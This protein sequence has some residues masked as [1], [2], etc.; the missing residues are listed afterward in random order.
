[1][2]RINGFLLRAIR[3]IREIRGS[4]YFSPAFSCYFEILNI[5]IS[6]S[7]VA[8]GGIAPGKPPAP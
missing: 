7:S 8:L 5:S 4:F 6:K 2:A 1:M 3:V